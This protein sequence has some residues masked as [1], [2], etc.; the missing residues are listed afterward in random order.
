MKAKKQETAP[1]SKK[2]KEL[3]LQ[4][5]DFYMK[6]NKTDILAEMDKRIEAKLKTSNQSTS[7]KIES[8][9]YQVGS[10]A[11]FTGENSGT[12]GDDT[13]GTTPSAQT[14][15]RTAT[16]GPAANG[17]GVL[18][19]VVANGETTITVP[20]GV[21]VENSARVY[22]GE[23]G[24]RIGGSFATPTHTAGTIVLNYETTEFLLVDYEIQVQA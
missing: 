24:L 21:F 18:T 11:V 17:D 6:K 10:L 19:I 15:K 14:A 20:G 9:R 5:I 13:G 4:L 8:L 16:T 3:V 22:E 7:R 1:S 23:A 2:L 12:T